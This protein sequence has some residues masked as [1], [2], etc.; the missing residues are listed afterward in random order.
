MKTCAYC[1]EEN[2]DEAIF[3]RRC[4][5]PLQVAPRPSHNVLIWLLVGFILVGLSY[6][7]F[8][9][10]SFVGPTPTPISNWMPTVGSV[11][12]RTK[13]P[14]TL[15]ACV[16]DTT[17]IRRGPGTQ[18]ET[19]GGLLSGTCLMILGRNDVASW[20]YIV[21]EDHQTGWVDVSLLNDAGGIGRVSI[22]DDSVL[23]NA[24]R[25]TL[26]SAE[27]AYGA[28]AYLTEVS[29]T[30]IPQSPINRYV[31]PC[32]DTASRIG[33]HV[34]CRME[35]AVCDYLP[36]VE[37]SP[38][39]CSDRPHPDHNFALIVFGEDWSDYDGQCII[40]SGYLEIDK[41]VLQIQALRRDQVSVC[42]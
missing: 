26:T 8:S 23:A 38:T 1:T 30:N 28:Q 13:E 3:C 10:G 31:V 18:Y 40:V 6:T 2:R 41:G 27:I 12:T 42:E 33:E 20:V 21:S 25:A 32:F 14:I 37:G 11:P 34:S 15:S 17:R 24:G 5:R 29:A 4:R 16:R 35:R 7:L 36:S 19:T 9:S 39:F 22:R